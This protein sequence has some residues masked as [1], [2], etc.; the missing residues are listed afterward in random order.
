MLCPCCASLPGAD[1]NFAAAV[2]RA[3]HAL[4]LWAGYAVMVRAAA[5]L[6]V[7]YQGLYE[8]VREKQDTYYL[9]LVSDGMSTLAYGILRA[10]QHHEL[11]A[12][13]QLLDSIEPYQ[14]LL[15]TGKQG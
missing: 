6:A 5:R 7:W 13:L 3:K 12:R 15:M 8:A 10:L 4:M 1:P 2:E 14:F 11:V 9:Q